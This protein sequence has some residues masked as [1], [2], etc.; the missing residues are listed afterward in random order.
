MEKREKQ[1]EYVKKDPDFE[2]HPVEVWTWRS[3]GRTGNKRRRP[4]GFARDGIV[5]EKES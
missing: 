5:R 1:F 4:K 2:R 3:Q